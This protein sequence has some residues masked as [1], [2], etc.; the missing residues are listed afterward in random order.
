LQGDFA[1]LCPAAAAE[2]GGTNNI[3]RATADRHQF[4]S[5][6]ALR[7]RQFN[8]H[9]GAGFAALLLKLFKLPARCIKLL[10]KRQH[11]FDSGQV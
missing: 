10:F 2:V 4:A 5:Q 3:G 9:L 11:A 6:G 1:Y 8:L 7:S